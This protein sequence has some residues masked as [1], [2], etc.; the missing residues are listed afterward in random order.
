MNHLRA[1]SLIVLMLCG[2]MLLPS[3]ARA[4]TTCTATMTD[5]QFGAV[6]ATGYATA[7]GTL[8]WQCNTSEF[9]AA[10][11]ARVK[12]CFSIGAG[13]AS[14]STVASR[15]MRS[16]PGN[17]AMAFQI[18]KDAA[19]TAPWTDSITPPSSA[20]ISTSYPLTSIF[21]LFATGSGSGTMAVHGRVPA[22][23][24]AAGTNYLNQF[25]GANARIVYRYNYGSTA[26][27]SCSSGAG[28]QG[29]PYD[30]TFAARASVPGLCEIS[31][32]SD[33]D[34]GSNPG[35]IAANRDYTS[36]ISMKCRS[37]TPWNVGLNNGQNAVGDTRRMRR[38]ATSNYVNY[39][40]YRDSG[41]GAR[42]GNTID[43]ETANG[44]GTGS[45]QAVTVFG[46]V[47][48]PQSALP[49]S[50]SDLITVTVTY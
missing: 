4:Q 27:G 50:Y 16:S 5:L 24:L 9:I 40:L 11:P 38:G 3:T 2:W 49:G 39:E 18:T 43:S 23:I 21:G 47:P 31:A 25:S 33:L 26:P 36:A 15:L 35:I 32:A 28:F 12:L 20:E 34:F 46:R 8:A 10:S 30:V 42:W 41:R 29:S 7:N 22:Q 44:T 13:S 48:A 1:I 17:D 6:D 37:R 45:T 14:G 19:F